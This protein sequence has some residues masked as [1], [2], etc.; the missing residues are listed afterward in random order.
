MGR[1]KKEKQDK[2]IFV[3]VS[4]SNKKLIQRIAKQM[5]MTNSKFMQFCVKQLYD[6]YQ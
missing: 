2:I 1:T 3:Y 6:S 5:G 4:Q